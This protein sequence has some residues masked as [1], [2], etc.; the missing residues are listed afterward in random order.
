MKLDAEHQATPLP[1]DGFLQQWLCLHEVRLLLQ[2]VDKV[3]LLHP[4][5]E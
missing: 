5:R 1:L 2:Q 3:I 4:Y